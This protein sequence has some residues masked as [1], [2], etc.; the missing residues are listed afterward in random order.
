MWWCLAAISFA[1]PD[2]AFARLDEP[3]RHAR[4]AKVENGQPMWRRRYG[5]IEA[6]TFGDGT[7]I[8]YLRHEDKTVAE[9]VWF[10][11]AGD[12][13]LRVAFLEDQPQLVAVAGHG[14]VDVSGW[15]EHVAGEWSIRAPTSPV[16]TDGGFELVVDEGRFL[17]QRFPAADVFADEFRDQLTQGCRCVATDRST[18]W[19]RDRPAA[20]YALMVPDPRGP[21]VVEALA[22]PWDDDVVV[23][24]WQAPTAAPR[25]DIGRSYMALLAEVVE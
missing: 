15:A 4:H 16:V 24:L 9:E 2:R 25:L 12:E 10:D 14:S 22:I 21:T 7:P 13:L 19:F 18:R 5:P 8:R 17:V 1:N 11:A 3:V 23:L 20:R 6:W